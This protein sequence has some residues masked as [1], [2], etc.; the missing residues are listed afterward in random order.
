MKYLQTKD[1]TRSNSIL[2]RVV[3]HCKSAHSKHWLI[4]GQIQTENGSVQ[5]LWAPEKMSP[6]MKKRKRKLFLSDNFLKKTMS[7]LVFCSK[8]HLTQLK[9]SGYKCAKQYK[10]IKLCW[11]WGSRPE[12]QLKTLSQNFFW[13][14]HCYLFSKTLQ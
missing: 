7:V 9:R 2:M 5:T 8:E 10:S 12:P 11:Y 4:Q 3:P 14:W 13:M 1:R 6:K